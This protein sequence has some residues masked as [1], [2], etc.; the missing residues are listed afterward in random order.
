[1]K[2]KRE[3][4]LFFLILPLFI[5]VLFFYFI[6]IFNFK[7]VN[8]K[9]E[10][11]KPYL[12]PYFIQKSPFNIYQNVKKIM[13]DFP[14]IK[15]ISLKLDPLK[16]KL[17]IEIEA[18]KIIA[19][20][21][22]YQ[23]CFYL[24]NS[25]RIIKPKILPTDNLLTINSLLPIEE[26]SLLNP[27]IKNLLVILFEYANWKPLIIKEII[28]HPNFDISVIDEKN[29][30]FLFDPSK[31]PE[32]QIKKMEIFFKKNY[33]GTRIDLRIPLKIYFK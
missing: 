28:I 18:T 22:H 31:N 2:R 7:E 21:C 4:S 24:D 8:I 16:Q 32:E 29:R 25:T 33:P 3:K 30:E 10:N 26:N 12:N 13:I 27:E 14:E 11:L 20:I 15:K 1:M 19:K 23:N 9:P 17:N 5:F 6:F